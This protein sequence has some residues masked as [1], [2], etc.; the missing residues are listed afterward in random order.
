MPPLSSSSP[1]SSEVVRSKERPTPLTLVEQWLGWYHVLTSLQRTIK[2]R[3][4]AARKEMRVA[5]RH[6]WWPRGFGEVTHCER[7]RS[8]EGDSQS[9]AA[10]KRLNQRPSMRMMKTKGQRCHCAL[11][12]RQ[13]WFLKLWLNDKCTLLAPG[14][15]ESEWSSV[16]A[17]KIWAR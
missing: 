16:L 17:S 1:L 11:D 13:D 12:T 8:E 7:R 2:Q 4:T 9:P 5:R 14:M 6:T 15:N 10:P 3:I